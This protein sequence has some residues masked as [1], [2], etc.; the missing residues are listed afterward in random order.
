MCVCIVA[1]AACNHGEEIEKLENTVSEQ[2]KRI[3]ELED[4]VR[5]L[6]KQRDLLNNENQVNTDFMAV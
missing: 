3:D 6:E 5:D 1:V 4:K 2:E